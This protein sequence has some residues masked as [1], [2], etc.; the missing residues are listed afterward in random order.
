M[1]PATED[2]IDLLDVTPKAHSTP[3]L[4][5]SRE[6]SAP[7]VAGPMGNALAFIQAGGTM[8]QLR[9]ML[10]LQKEWEASEALKA[11]NVAFSDFKAEAVRVLKGKDVTDGPLKGKS[12]AELHGVVDAV[13]PALSRHGLSAS[14]KVTRDEPQW[15]EVTCTLKH[16]LGH[17]ESVSMGGPPDAGGAKNAIQSRASTVSYLQ[18]YTLKAVCGV[19]EGGDD[20]DGNGGVQSMRRELWADKAAA[21][22]TAKDLQDVRRDGTKAFQDAK[23]R[24]G[25]L[26]FATAVKTRAADLEAEHA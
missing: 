5:P 14:W 18:R 13:T 25:Y 20:N 26:S 7:A 9:D 8:D 10:A 16:V 3:A 15:I 4:Q 24:D 17:S 12:Y 22:K 1:Q 23:D 21:A 11:Y 19:A 2:T 6:V